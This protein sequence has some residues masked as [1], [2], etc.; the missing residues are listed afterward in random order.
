[1]KGKPPNTAEKA[2]FNALINMG[3]IVC[4]TQHGEP[5]PCEI[6]H[7]EGKTRA[8]AHLKTIPLCP[9]H[10]RHGSDSPPFISRHPYKARFEEAYGTEAE[11]LAETNERINFPF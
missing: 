2:R 3:C 11:L 10:H 7:T 5:T 1:M 8:G 4:L 9:G 6:H